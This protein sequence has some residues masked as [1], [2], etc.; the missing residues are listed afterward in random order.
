MSPDIIVT[1]ELDLDKDLDIIKQ[2]FNSGVKVVATIHAKDVNEL[3]RKSS[4]EN[5]LEEKYFARFVVLGS[6]NGPGTLNAVFNE[7]LNCLYCRW[8]WNGF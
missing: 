3:R 2:A 5:V 6:E 8:A 1:D 7:K 4:F